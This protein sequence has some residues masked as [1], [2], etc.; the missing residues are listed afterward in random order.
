M[1]ERSVV[2][3]LFIFNR[4]STIFFLYYSKVHE[5]CSCY[6]VLNNFIGNSDCFNGKFGYCTMEL[7]FG[8]FHIK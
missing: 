3:V 5:F 7:L 4:N 8:I 2:Q 6:Q 1:I